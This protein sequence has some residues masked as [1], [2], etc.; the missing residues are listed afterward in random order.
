MRDFAYV[1]RDSVIPYITSNAKH[2]LDHLA[3]REGENGEA[4]PSAQTISSCTNI[5]V[6]G[7][8]RAIKSLLEHNLIVCT[9]GKLLGRSNRYKVTLPPE[10]VRAYAD[11]HP[12][13]RVKVSQFARPEVGQGDLPPVGRGDARGG[14][15]AAAGVGHPDLRSKTILRE[16]KQ[17]NTQKDVSLSVSLCHPSVATNHT[18]PASGRVDCGNGTVTTM[19]QPIVCLANGRYKVDRIH[20]ARTCW[21][22][23]VSNEEAYKFWRYNQVRG[24]PLLATM[25]LV[26][27]ARRWRDTWQREHPVEFEREYNLRLE[28]RR[29]RER[30]AAEAPRVA[31]PSGDLRSGDILARRN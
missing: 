28:A 11:K 15:G 22:I 18:P 25:E 31:A 13:K 12:N 1:V 9:S 14:S 5:S 6:K 16:E 23:G 29:R 24:W 26:D 19:Q 2:V 4:W 20:A 17:T 27:I 10:L 8:Q 30:Q 7:V 3:S 21:E